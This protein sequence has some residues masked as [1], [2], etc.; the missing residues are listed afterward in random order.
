MGGRSLAIEVASG[1]VEGLDRAD[2]SLWLNPFLPHFVREAQ[3]CGGEVRVARA[4]GGV[5]AVSVSDPVERVATVFSRSRSTAER[6]VRER[7]PYGMYS[8]FSFEPT[9]ERFDILTVSLGS[10][11][12]SF[13]LRHLVRPL[14]PE[15][16]RPVLELMREVYG[17]VNERW[18]DGL[19]N[20]FE[21]GLLAEVDGRLAGV[22]WVSTVGSHA[23]LHSLTVRAP[24]RR[25]GLGTD[26][27]FARLLWAQRAGAEEALSEISD[28]NIGS[29]AI[30]ARGGMR[31][32][33]QVYLHRPL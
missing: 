15:D 32:V 5:E 22:G 14:R 7:G 3:R 17:A 26:L 6:F 12:P 19:P 16:A 2:L 29:Q 8:D 21:T 9:A 28:Q 1:S 11:A 33:G 13:H 4:A 18:Y 31:R 23:R 27:L 25:M 20:P 10:D 30:A 24:Y